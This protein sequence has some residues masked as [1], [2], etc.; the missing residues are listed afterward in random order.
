MRVLIAIDD[1]T[2][3]KPMSSF[4]EN[5]TRK[6][7]EFYVIK[8]L[9][10]VLVGNVLAVLPSAVLDDI[11]KQRHQYAAT[12]VRN[13]ALALRDKLKVQNIHEM[14]IEGI[15]IP[16]VINE[17]AARNRIDLTVVGTHHRHGLSR[18]LEGSVSS[19]IIAHSPCSVLIVDRSIVKSSPVEKD[20]E[21]ASSVT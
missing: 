20:H 8:V 21:C 2:F 18:M 13:M 12:V 4:F 10:P 17:I 11:S 7:T 1:D 5:C 9:E 19:A 14:V 15:S 6:P 3:I 16:T